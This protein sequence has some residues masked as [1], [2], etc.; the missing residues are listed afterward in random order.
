[1]VP[2]FTTFRE[3]CPPLSRRGLLVSCGVAMTAIVTANDRPQ[4]PFSN[5]PLLE[6]G[7]ASAGASAPHTRLRISSRGLVESWP[8]GC[9]PS[10]TE[11]WTP[12]DARQFVSG[13]AELIREAEVSTASIRSELREQLRKTGR[14][15]QIQEAEDS[16]IRVVTETEVLELRCPAPLLLAERF[17][18]ASRLQTFVRVERRISNLGCI[19]ECGRQTAEQLCAKANERLRAEHPAAAP[20]TLD[21]LMM[22]R[23][24][25]DGGRFV[26]FRREQ[27]GAEFWT[28]CVTESPGRPACVTV[29]PPASLVR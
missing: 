27:A 25:S 28:T 22:V 23:S 1:M 12:E 21:D 7:T 5:P 3:L 4:S 18:E 10:R 24:A 29:I 6:W 13:I 19:V 14:S 20:W 8:A 17:P 11:Q 9:G 2:H 26:Q 15:F 16:L